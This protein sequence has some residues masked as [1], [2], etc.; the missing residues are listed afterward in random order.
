M[1][2]YQAR[3]RRFLS[4]GPDEIPLTLLN[5][6]TSFGI[7]ELEVANDRRLD[8][9]V[10]LGTHA[11]M[12]TIGEYIFG[13]SGP[14]ATKFYLEHFVD[15]DTDDQRFSEIYE[16]LHEMRNVFAHQ[17]MSLRSHKFALDYREEK[18]WWHGPDGVHI[19]PSVYF[20]AFKSRFPDTAP[21]RDYRKFVSERDL[22]IRRCE[23]VANWIGL[24]KKHQVRKTIQ[25]LASAQSPK[26]DEIEKIILKQL[27]DEGGL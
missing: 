8:T 21:E 15:G 18:G 24:A 17:W 25:E 14:S 26:F 12:Q 27:A 22:R 9:L 6:I 3:L 4:N 16:L 20:M 11:I 5:S 23:F 19:N 7:K 2:T 13:M 10:F 1:E